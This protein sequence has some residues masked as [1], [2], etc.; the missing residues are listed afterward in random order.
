M[1]LLIYDSHL[2]PLLL[3]DVDYV[4][5]KISLNDYFILCCNW[6][7]TREFLGKE[8]LSLF[9]VNVC[10]SQR[11][12]YIK[13]K[14]MRESKTTSVIKHNGLTKCC[15]A[16]HTGD[17]FFLGSRDFCYRDF[18]RNSLLFLSDLTSSTWK[19]GVKLNQSFSTK[20]TRDE[21]PLPIN[22]YRNIFK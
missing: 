19:K 7:T 2:R 3:N 6:G 15:Q 14:A 1:H 10:K 16:T 17:V 12:I 21:A 22:K 11:R 8:S 9:K 20:T 4:I 13:N 5:C 18:L